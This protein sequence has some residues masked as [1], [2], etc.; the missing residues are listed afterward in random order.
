LLEEFSGADIKVHS[1][2]GLSEL[3]NEVA[4]LVGA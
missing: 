4:A 1:L 2:D 3:E